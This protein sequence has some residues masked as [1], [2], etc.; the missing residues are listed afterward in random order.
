MTDIIAFVDQNQLTA[1][2]GYD[3]SILSSTNLV[4]PAVLGSVSDIG[5]VDTSDLQN[6]SVLVFNSTTNKWTSTIH[7]NLQDIEAGEF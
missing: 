7:L 1:S 6:G 4:N 5:N 3:T 2:V